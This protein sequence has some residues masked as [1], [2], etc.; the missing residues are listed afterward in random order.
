MA[1]PYI[2]LKEK[3]YG[4]FSYISANKLSKLFQ[5]TKKSPSQELNS[6]IS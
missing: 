6:V 5:K 3:E 4:W 2:G 1:D